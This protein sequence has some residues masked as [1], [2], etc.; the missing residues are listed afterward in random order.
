MNTFKSIIQAI[1]I[2]A[3][4]AVTIVFAAYEIADVYNYA[5]EALAI[6]YECR[7]GDFSNAGSYAVTKAEDGSYTVEFAARG[8][9]DMAVKAYY[10]ANGNYIYTEKECGGYILLDVVGSL[11]LGLMLAS[12]SYL[13]YLFLVWIAECIVKFVKNAKEKKKVKAVAGLDGDTDFE[14]VDLKK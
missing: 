7:D 11:F 8:K 12:I 9:D 4:A 14:M 6:E 10:D 2:Y 13:I 1:F 3:V 5:N